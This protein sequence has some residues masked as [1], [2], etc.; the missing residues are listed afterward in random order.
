MKRLS[1]RYVSVALV[2]LALFMVCCKKEP[3]KSQ[4]GMFGT[5]QYH[6]YAVNGLAHD[7]D[8]LA[9]V[10]VKLTAM[11]NANYVKWDSIEFHLQLD[12][13]DSAKVYIKDS[14][15]GA[16]RHILY[17]LTYSARFDQVSVWNEAKDLYWVSF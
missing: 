14:L 1:Y 16:T 2:A 11:T 3:F 6:H 4:K 8:Q 13:G 12:K 17:T 5:K 15:I 7:T 10:R 9:D